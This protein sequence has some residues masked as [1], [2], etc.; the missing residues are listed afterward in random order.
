[1]SKLF[2]GLALVMGVILYFSFSMGFVFYKY[3]YWFVLD[4]FPNLPEITFYQ[5]V[6]LKLFTGILISIRY[7][8][9][10]EELYKDGA[11]ERTSQLFLMPWISVLIGYFIY[12]FINS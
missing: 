2:A 12:L 9:L 1:M 10:K 8:A 6:G 5:A 11:V 3:W 4:V 7:N